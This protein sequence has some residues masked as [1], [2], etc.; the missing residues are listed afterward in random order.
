M[1]ASEPSSDL[2][3]STDDEVGSATDP[4]RWLAGISGAEEIWVDWQLC[5]TPDSENDVAS[6]VLP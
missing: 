5:P 6:S 4:L 1:L 3:P 2:R